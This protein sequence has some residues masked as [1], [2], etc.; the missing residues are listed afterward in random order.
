MRDRDLFIFFSPFWGRDIQ[1]LIYKSA[2]RRYFQWAD[3]KHKQEE[4]S[5]SPEHSGCNQVNPI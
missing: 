2:L 1:R 3:A 4:F 5:W